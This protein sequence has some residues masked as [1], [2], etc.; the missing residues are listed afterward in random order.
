M[1]D[2]VCFLLL[3]AY[4]SSE[5]FQNEWRTMMQ[6]SLLHRIQQIASLQN[7]CGYPATSGISH[8]FGEPVK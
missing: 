1:R 7:N 2:G 6:F 4:I 8:K 3:V 5:K